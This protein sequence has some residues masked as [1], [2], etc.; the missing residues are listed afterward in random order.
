MSNLN[1]R[2]SSSSS[3][4]AFQLAGRPLASGTPTN[5][6]SL[7]Y[8]ATTGQ[9]EYATVGTGATGPTGPTG[10]TG[11]TGPTGAGGDASSIQGATIEAG[12]P[13]AGEIMQYNAATNQWEYVHTGS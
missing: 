8:N 12:P 2:T 11:V 1:E 4:N 3:G 9:W 5:G 13:L 10:P 7:V 6:Q